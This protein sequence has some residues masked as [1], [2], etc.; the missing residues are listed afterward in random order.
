MTPGSWPRYESSDSDVIAGARFQ[1][2]NICFIS[3]VFA[4]LGTPNHRVYQRK[5]GISSMTS[6]QAGA[7][8]LSANICYSF[9]CFCAG[10]YHQS[11]CIPANHWNKGFSGDAKYG[12]PRQKISKLWWKTSKIKHII[13]KVLILFVSIVNTQCW[14]SNYRNERGSDPAIGDQAVRLLS[15]KCLE[16]FRQVCF[17]FIAFSGINS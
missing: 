13:E 4:V 6:S 17:D 12:G 14:G 16:R 11:S 8:F 2:T 1:N 10:G 15:A 3:V 9:C 7:R 5:Y